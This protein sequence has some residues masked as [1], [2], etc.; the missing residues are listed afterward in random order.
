MPLAC[1]CGLATNF[2]YAPTVLG[3]ELDTDTKTGQLGLPR[4]HALHVRLDAPEGS[5][6]ALAQ[7]TRD[8]SSR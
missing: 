4:G 2:E 8:R 3:R 5:D 6:A 7:L 1:G